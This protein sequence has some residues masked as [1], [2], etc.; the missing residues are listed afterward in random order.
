MNSTIIPVFRSTVV[1]V[2]MLANLSVAQ[3]QV[4]QATRWFSGTLSLQTYMKYPVYLT[5]VT[6]KDS[7]AGWMDIPSQ[8]IGGI[9]LAGI[10]LTG[11]E[12]SFHTQLSIGVWSKCS[13][14]STTDGQYTGTLMQSG[15]PLTASFTATQS[16]T[17]PTEKNFGTRTDTLVIEHDLRF[18]PDEQSVIAGTLTVPK[19]SA[20]RVPLVIMISGSGQQDRDE[21]ILGFKPFAILA[22]ELAKAGVASFRYDDRCTGASRGDMFSFTTKDLAADARFALMQLKQRTD[23]D[24]ARMFILGHSEGGIIAGMLA[25]EMNTPTSKPIAGIILMASSAVRGDSVI[26]QQITGGM[27]RDGKSKREIDSVAQRQTETYTAVRTGKGM[28][29]IEKDIRNAAIKQF[30]LLPPIQRAMMKDTVEGL[31]SLTQSKLY[32]L[33]MPW[34]K[35]FIDYNPAYDLRSLRI[36]VL[37]MFGNKDVQVD[38]V[39]NGSVLRQMKEEKS[40][41]RDITI[42]NIPNANHL[43]Q[44]AQSGETSEY[45]MLK[46]EFAPKVIDTVTSWLKQK[47]SLP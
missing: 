6:T 42:V 19:S 33:K 18:S 27:R 23:I 39:Q 36:P 10:N 35:F 1:L 9:P 16:N 44:E 21:T 2:L 7:L 45:G 40:G 34:F 17:S 8:N 26:L 41:E 3:S 14:T 11:K 32:Q 38:V 28:E 25:S 4:A 29:D 47:A 12:F 20:A 37:A 46:K 22:R 31:Q 24:S 15:I 43:F 13:A 5:I 30:A